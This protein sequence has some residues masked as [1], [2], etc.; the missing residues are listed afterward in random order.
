[1]N[2]NI[3]GSKFDGFWKSLDTQKD[4]IDFNK[5][6]ENNKRIWKYKK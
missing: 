5:M 3:Y 6:Y 4:K 2:Y 1:M